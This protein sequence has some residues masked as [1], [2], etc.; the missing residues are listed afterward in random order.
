MSREEAIGRSADAV[1]SAILKEG[2]A[3]FVFIGIDLDGRRVNVFS[4]GEGDAKENGQS[5]AQRWDRL[6]G[7]MHR[8]AMDWELDARLDDHEDRGHEL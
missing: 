7:A 2:F 6:T 3:D 5:N 8:Q 1:R 4:I